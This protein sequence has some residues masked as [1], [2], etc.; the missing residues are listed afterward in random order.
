MK[1]IADGDKV[2]STNPALTVGKSEERV[3]KEKSRSEGPM[4]L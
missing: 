3:R 4:L 2:M 1:R